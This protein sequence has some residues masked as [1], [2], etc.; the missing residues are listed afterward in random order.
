[1]D[2]LN[3]LNRK[4]LLVGFLA[5]LLLGVQSV[6]ASTIHDHAQHQ[7]DCVLCHFD[8]HDQASLAQADFKVFERQG[9]QFTAFPTHTVYSL[10]FTPYQGRS[11]PHFYS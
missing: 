4:Y 9:I 7:V 11:P 5:L 3:R 6:Q 8:S 2:I 10:H 1:M